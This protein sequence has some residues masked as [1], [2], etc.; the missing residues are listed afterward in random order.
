MD[1]R[2]LLVTLRFSQVLVTINARVPLSYHGIY[3]LFPR[4]PL[5]NKHTNERLRSRN[6]QWQNSRHVGE[7]WPGYHIFLDIFRCQPLTLCRF[8]SSR[9][10]F[11][12]LTFQQE[13]KVG[14]LGLAYALS[15]SSYFKRYETKNLEFFKWS[16]EN[17]FGNLCRSLIEKIW[18]PFKKRSHFQETKVNFLFKVFL[19]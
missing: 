17:D 14:S 1:E 5:S 16:W 18:F 4:K 19:Y 13:G 7:L 11:F 15:R 12:K 2:G 10:L 3:Q 6:T 9:F 8:L